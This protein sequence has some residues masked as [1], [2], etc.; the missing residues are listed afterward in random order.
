M[1]EPVAGVTTVSQ[2]WHRGWF[3]RAGGRSGAP[4]WSWERPDGL[5]ADAL[6][7]AR[8]RTDGFECL[9]RIGG[10]QKVIAWA[11]ACQAREIAGFVGR[12][13]ADPPRGCTRAEA[14]D[15]ATAEIGLM[16]RESAGAAAWKVDEARRLV[17]RFPAT[18]AVLAAGEITEYK[19]RII[20][21]G[22]ADLD[23]ELVARVQAR[24]LPSAPKQTPGQLRAAVRRA[25]HQVDER[26]AERR[27]ERQR[28]KR[29]VALYPER[30]G[31][32]TLSATLPAVEAVGV[33]AVLDE[34]A[35]RAGGAGEGRGMD[36]R[37]AD[38]LVDLVLHGTGNCSAGTA[39]ALAGTGAG[40]A[41]DPGTREAGAA[42]TGTRRA[43]GWAPGRAAHPA[44]MAAGS[45]AGPGA[46]SENSP[47]PTAAASGTAAASEI[48][49]VSEAGAASETGAGHEL[50]GT[51]ETSP[52]EDTARARHE[53]GAEAAGGGVG[54]GA[55]AVATGAAWAGRL[56]G[57]VSSG[58][59]PTLARPVAMN[60]QIRVTV[61]LST[62][63]G[64]DDQPGELAGY[65][66]ITATQARGL[67]A[68]PG[69]TWRR[70]VTDPLSGTLLDVGTTRYSPP[71][72]LAEHV[73]ARD[74]TCRFPGCR[75]PAHRCDLDHTIPFDPAGGTG[76]TAATNL[77]PRC[78]RD[79]RRK[80]RPGWHVQQFTDGTVVWTTPSGHTYTV[81]PPPLAPPEP[82]T[83]P[84]PPGDDPPPFDPPPF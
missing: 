78:R 46:S 60:V 39:A 63:M 82:A 10:W 74:Q 83:P 73:I 42:E 41:A 36:A 28:R 58:G 54:A 76:P 43:P 44:T 47:E 20:A 8:D 33:Y 65:G 15:P 7:S 18:W 24:V 53:S 27:H 72:G 29:A 80:Q 11:Q 5:L 40:G 51:H 70:L 57:V 21:E 25:V 49:A 50:G 66:P 59:I 48:A 13:E 1:F 75:V 61:A 55:A 38:A 71:P 32:A 22:C 56:P 84:A 34:C 2:P 69:S 37:R 64:L 35:R 26:A 12:A 17:E 77:G 62:L 45:A 6:E 81:E 79:H 52:G 31:M 3:A 67:A 30:D 9:E 16:L 14:V 19:A 68:D 4:R 23:D